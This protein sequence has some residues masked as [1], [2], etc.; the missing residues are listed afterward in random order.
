MKKPSSCHFVN[1]F[2]PRWIADRTADLPDGAPRSDRFRRGVVKGKFLA[3][4]VALALPLGLAAT[5]PSAK[6]QFTV[7]VTQDATGVTLSG[8]GSINTA[9]LNPPT[10]GGGSGAV[11]FPSIPVIGVGNAASAG[12]Y[13]GVTT[14][15]PSLGS[16]VFPSSTTQSGD[17]VAENADGGT[18]FLPVGY[19]SGAPLLGTAFFAG[20]SFA[21]FGLTDG[22]Y[23]STWGTGATAGFFDVQ[24]GALPPTAPT[25]LTTAFWDGR[26]DGLW[27]DANWATT[28]A[29]AQTTLTPS[30]ITDVT[31]SISTGA[32][33]QNTALGQNFTIHSLTVN[34]PIAVTIGSG[35][36]GPFTLTIAGNAG[37]G[38]T[39]NTGSHLTVN[40][41][42]V[43]GGAS[44]T[45]AVNGTGVAFLNGALG[46]TNGLNKIG[47]GALFLNGVTTGNVQVVQGV[48][49][50]T[51]SI[52]G[53][54]TNA[55][56]VSPGD[57][58][59]TLKVGG[60]YTQLPGAVLVIGIGGTA[61]GQFDALQVAGKVQL[62]GALELLRLNNFTLT[63]G[64]KIPF[65][66][67]GQGISGGFTTVISP[68]TGHGLLQPTLIFGP[69]SIVLEDAQ[70]SFAAFA[71]AA[72]LS[73]NEISVGRALDGVVS[74]RRADALINYLDAQSL[75]KL[76]GDLVKIDPEQLT[77]MFAVAIAEANVQSLNLQR[78][79]DDIR[80]GSTGFSAAGLAMN[81]INQGSYSGPVELGAAAAGPSGPDGKMSKE[82]VPPPVDQ[83]WGAF[84][85]GTG[86]WVNVGDTDN[87][88]GYNLE[89]GGFTLGVDYKVCPNF[90]V[91]VSFGY[92]GTTADLTD[93]GRVWT[94]GGKVGLYST[95]FIG[96]W[97]VDTAANGGYNSYDTRREGLGGEAR[98]STDGGEFNG[99]I[100]TGYDIK[101]GL[102]TFGP[103]ATFNYTYVGLDGFTEHGSLA[104][105]N[106][107]GSDEESERTALG[108][109]VRYD[110]KVGHVLIK[111]E[112]RAAWQHEFGDAT[113]ALNSS[114]A[115]GAGGAGGA[116]GASDVFTV[117]GPKIGRDSALLSGG[118]AVQCSE[119][120]STYVYYDGV[121][122]CSNYHSSS[123]TG[124]LRVDF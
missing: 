36:G 95:G 102:F 115:S 10:F 46:A 112:L 48:L 114:F 123:V 39:V 122:G 18:I 59:G 103:T 83:R 117:D 24:I 49:G 17:D 67:A 100:G 33:N 121:L 1:S 76:P 19:V 72:R 27:T 81:G 111:P 34:D 56:A 22:T 118:L 60:N 30:A 7:T 71:G 91:G 113:Y 38:I 54:V 108:V 42:V 23:T 90:A 35:A 85:S 32:Q 12:A 87:A 79:T 47:S 106:I 109:K 99:L 40:A 29:D 37:T 45:I 97:Y 62:N 94:N 66:S 16:P 26:T 82:V 124:G 69:N 9:S 20:A 15:L 70:S 44:D 78:R 96:G 101:K 104:P 63:R 89:S 51:G 88:R 86:E 4:A 21:S 13:S 43:L 107:H 120:C 80:S 53:N 31:F 119:R 74:D 55:A 2:R 98:S 5:A 84:L 68:F 64:E 25:A 116:G 3:G 50:G 73:P 61:P 77:S 65:L 41:N 58:P 105:L 93:R 110:W 57:A 6:A 8:A 14:V 52:S 28:A 11:F 92:T 75:G